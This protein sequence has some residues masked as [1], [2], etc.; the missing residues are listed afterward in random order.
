MNEVFRKAYNLHKY[1]K[2]ANDGF[3]SSKGEFIDSLR[4]YYFSH[5]L[6]AKYS[7]VIAVYGASFDDDILKIYSIQA[8]SKETKKHICSFFIH[9]SAL[10]GKRY[11]ITDMQVTGDILRKYI[12]HTDKGIGKLPSLFTNISKET[13][14]ILTNDIEKGLR[15]SKYF[16]LFIIK[17]INNLK[18]TKKDFIKGKSHL[19]VPIKY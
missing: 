3:E 6:I 9:I 4:L 5:Y 10:V 13:E 1:F 8:V 2:V 11:C 7:D 19:T 17:I 18:L 15:S 14:D 16:S 12:D